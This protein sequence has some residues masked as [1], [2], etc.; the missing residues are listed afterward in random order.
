MGARTGNF[1]DVDTTQVY[2]LGERRTER[3]V[4]VKAGN[5]THVGDR[6]WIYIKANANLAA[7]NVVQRDDAV[8]FQGELGTTSAKTPRVLGVAQHAIASGSYGWIVRRGVC[9]VLSGGVTASTVIVAA[10]SGKAIDVVSNADATTDTS[11]R[12][13]GYALETAADTV[14][15]AAVITL[16]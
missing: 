4:T 6:E 10:G 15:G 8:A 9:E 3:S 5:S 16:P 7:G 14:L 12:Q 13:I 1:S 11:D 2:P